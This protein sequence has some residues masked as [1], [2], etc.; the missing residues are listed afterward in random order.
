M[1]TI[2]QL[3]LFFVFFKLHTAVLHRSWLSG[4]QYILLVLGTIIISFHPSPE[5]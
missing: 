5:C 1:W 3:G 2:R 4:V